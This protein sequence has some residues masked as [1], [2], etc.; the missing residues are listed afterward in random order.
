MIFFEWEPFKGLKSLKGLSLARGFLALLFFLPTLWNCAAFRSQASA[1]VRVKGSDTMLILNRQWAEAYMKKHSGVSVYV[2]GGGSATGIQA[3]VEGKADICASSRTL[4]PEEVS[5]LAGRYQTIGISFLVAKD[6]LSIYLHPDNPVKDLTLKQIKEIFSGKVTNWSEV[7]GKDETILVLTRSPNS[8]TYLYF[9]EHL[10]EE[11]PYGKT[12]QIQA[13]TASIVETIRQNPNA[14]GYGGIGYGPDLTHCRVNGIAPS[15]E[16]ARYN[17]YPVTRYL[18]FYTVNKPQG[19]AKNFIDW[20]LSAE[21]QRVVKEA[22][23]IP[24]WDITE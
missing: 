5:L 6:A 4:R 14:I 22:G 8:G 21:G 15:E 1:T 17:L 12:A 7:G 3:L 19:A 9:Q 20:V 13:T 16:A 18:Y 10:L 24:L 23:Y 2:E 11:E